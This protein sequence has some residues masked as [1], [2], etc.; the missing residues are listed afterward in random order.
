MKQLIVYCVG[1]GILFS[2]HLWSWQGK[3]IPLSE[4]AQRRAAVLAK[5]ESG[6]AAVFCSAEPM[7]RNDDVPYPYRQNSTFLYLTGIHQQRAALLLLPD[8]MYTADSVLV[9]TVV[10]LPRGGY[11]WIGEI[12]PLDV[13]KNL[14]GFT[15]L[16]DL[17]LPYDTLQSVLSAVLPT[18]RIL[19]YTPSLPETFIDRIANI[20]YIS[21][22]EAKKQ[23]QERFPN[24]EVRSASDLIQ[25]LRVVKSYSEIQLIQ[26]AVDRTIA[27]ISDVMRNCRDCQY[28]YEVERM[29][30]QS[31]WKSGV[32]TQAYPPIVATGK[33]ALY[34]HYEAKTSK[35][36]NGELLLVDCGAEVQGY[37]ADITRTF[38][39]N[40]KFTLAQKKLYERVLAAR[41]SGIAA[42]EIGATLN[43]VHEVME[44][45]LINGMC[46]L[47]IEKTPEDAR[48]LIL[49]GFCH[50]IGLDVHDVGS[51]KQPLEAGMTVALEPAIYIPD[52]PRYP[53]E[54]RGIGIRVEDNVLV[55]ESGC[56]VFSALAPTTIE[57]I[58]GIMK[59]GS[60]PREKTKQQ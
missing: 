13:Q 7:M 25:Q 11:S 57:E 40:G 19:Y 60:S 42:I 38:P 48:K 17:V 32:R 20:P 1:I 41:D 54:Y 12:P 39:V 47:G 44:R 59:R 34:P 30:E 14:Y 5:M 27:A 52:D 45:V 6:T 37:A 22:R 15:Q 36:R 28:E 55:T 53:A 49:H 23:L 10:F 46:S 3:S 35:L 51:P 50:F 2:S 16:T 58:E 43:S 29:L 21:W 4:Y 24:L 9:H 8:G 56:T 31:L 26:E 33:N 18:V